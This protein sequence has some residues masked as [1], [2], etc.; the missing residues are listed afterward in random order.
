MPENRNRKRP[1]RLDAEG[2]WQYAIRILGAR[3]YSTHDLRRKLLGRGGASGTVEQVLSRLEQGGYLNDRRYAEMYA[4]TRL[5]NQGF[6]RLR[7]LRDLRQHRVPPAIIDSVI[8]DLYRETDETSLIEQYLRRKYRGVDLS[9]HL[10]EPRHLAGAYRKLRLAGF[11]NSNSIRVLK[12]FAEQAEQ[13]E[14]FEADGE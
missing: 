5:E 2:L 14:S 6:G 9:D 7:V 1:R 4:S 13:L 11:S 10:T 3:A 8:E 12:R